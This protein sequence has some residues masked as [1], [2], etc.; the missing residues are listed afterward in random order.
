MVFQNRN[1]LHGVAQRLLNF[2]KEHVCCL[3]LSQLLCIPSLRCG[4]LGADDQVPVQLPF[5]LLP[6]G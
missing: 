5:A 1:L 2:F 3:C 6:I 4:W